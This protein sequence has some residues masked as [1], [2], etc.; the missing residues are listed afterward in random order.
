MMKT[1]I[2]N[3]LERYNY[4][5]VKLSGEPDALYERHVMSDQVI[6]AAL[7]TAREKYEAIAHSV[8]DVLSQRWLRTQQTYQ[9][10]NVKRIY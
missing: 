1:D 10:R 6:P 2:K 3:L 8:R 4:G 5:P 7:T 9:Q